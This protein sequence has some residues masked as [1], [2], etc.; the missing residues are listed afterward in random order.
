M[1]DLSDL[2]NAAVSPTA[3]GFI[4]NPLRRLLWVLVRPWFAHLAAQT[5]AAALAA[6]QPTT[7]AAIDG[8]RKDQMA[9]A[10]RL[11]SIEATL[12]RTQA[13]LAELRAAQGRE[14]R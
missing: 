3:T 14:A 7:Q 10:H 6:V 1:H 9:L 13:E 12:A 5:E 8:W 4:L 2:R 11:A